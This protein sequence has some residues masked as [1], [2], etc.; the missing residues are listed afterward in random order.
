[1]QAVAGLAEKQVDA[2]LISAELRQQSRS[3]CEQAAEL[4]IPVL[5]ERHEFAEAGALVS[6]G[7]DFVKEL[8][9]VE[10]QVDRILQTDGRGTLALAPTQPEFIINLRTARALGITIPAKLMKIATK[11]ID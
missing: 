4:K 11:L 7:T 8:K 10:S 5:A 9:L 6:Y 2:L 3:I 1:M